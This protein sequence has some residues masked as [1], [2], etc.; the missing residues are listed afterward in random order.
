MSNTNVDDNPTAVV[1]L[2]SQ[3]TPVK[4]CFDEAREM[5]ILIDDSGFAGERMVIEISAK[6]WPSV[7]RSVNRY[8]LERETRAASDD[9]T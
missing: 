6:L 3:P 2:L 4:V 7:S 5:V 8:L 9:N 1:T